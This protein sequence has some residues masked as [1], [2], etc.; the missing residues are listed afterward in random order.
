[1]ARCRN[2]ATS[3]RDA[4]MVENSSKLT[5]SWTSV[6]KDAGMERAA[7]HGDGNVLY[8]ESPEWLCE[9]DAAKAE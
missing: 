4:E 5:T 3:L 9:K 7:R 2:F 6:L 1:M 8:G